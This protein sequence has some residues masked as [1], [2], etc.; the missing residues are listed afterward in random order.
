MNDPAELR[1]QVIREPQPL[2]D[3]PVKLTRYQA[4][5]SAAIAG[6]VAAGHLGYLPA[7]RDV[8]DLLH[9]AAAEAAGI[10]TRPASGDAWQRVDSWPWPQP[11]PTA[12][13][14]E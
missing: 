11:G 3:V 12:A 14:P 2:D 7:L 6:A 1:Q 13:Q 8:E 4:H 5:K 10:T 9:A